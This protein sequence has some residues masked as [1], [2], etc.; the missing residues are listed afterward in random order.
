MNCAAEA[1]AVEK[2]FALAKKFTALKVGNKVTISKER[3]KNHF[4]EHFS[5][6]DLPVPPELLNPQEYSYLADEKIPINE[7]P[8]K[9]MKSKMQKCPL[10]M[11]KALEQTD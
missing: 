5:A 3:L 10:K 2:E 6:R 8:P 1:R 11:E 9:R 4:E 7:D